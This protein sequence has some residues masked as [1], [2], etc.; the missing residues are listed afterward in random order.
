MAAPEGPLPNFLVIGAMKAGTTSL[1]HYLRAHPEV[2]MP[3]LKEVDFFTEELNWG[4]GWS[5]YHRQFAGVEPGVKAI[6]EA[7]TSYTKYPRYGGT[8]ERIAKNLPGAR[9]VYVVRDPF[10]RIRSH[11]QHNV[12]LGE[13]SRDLDDAIHT[14]PN[15]VDYT[16]YSTQLERYADHFPRDRMLV[17]T[18]DELR[19]K[20][21]ET[22]H[23]VY[24]FL[25]VDGGFVDPTMEQ[26][27]YKT[28]E[29][30]KYGPV[31][32]GIRRGLKRAFPKSVGLWRGRFVPA[33]IKRALG[34]KG[35]TT[36]TTEEGMSA[37]TRNYVGAELADE[38]HGVRTWLGPDFDGWGIA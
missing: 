23:R 5:W 11:Y 20:R 32:S 8:A 35:E 4:K 33:P 1:Y 13:E 6:G 14:N 22:V 31:V 38:M 37:A 2:F 28:E 26:E 7:S 21:R 24:E 27:F 9:L 16:R 34:R 18:S 29:R 10:E 19:H 3:K 36:S 12:T 15:Y 25:D 17:I 30:P